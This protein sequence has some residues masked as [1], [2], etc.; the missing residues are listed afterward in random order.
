MVSNLREALT[1]R[2]SGVL[3]SEEREY[4]GEGGLDDGG[5]FVIEERCIQL[6]DSQHSQRHRRSFAGAH[7]KRIDLTRIDLTKQIIDYCERKR[8]APQLSGEGVEEGCSSLPF[9]FPRPPLVR[10]LVNHVQARLI[11]QKGFFAVPEVQ[12]RLPAELPPDPGLVPLRHLQSSPS[13]PSCYVRAGRL[14]FPFLFLFIYLFFFESNNNN[15]NQS[16]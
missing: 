7:N 12:M 5:E 6:I 9:F 1:M 2:S 16:E 14:V 13:I 11:F 3:Y 8:R 15:N 10:H 4:L